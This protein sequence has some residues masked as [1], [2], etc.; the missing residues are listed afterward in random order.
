[1]GSQ[2]FQK[3]HFLLK[4]Q[5][6]WRFKF[7]LMSLGFINLSNDM[8]SLDYILGL[9]LLFSMKKNS[10]SHILFCQY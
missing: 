5:V 3:L 7:D 2:E 9:I 8:L 4:N 1:M 10:L 6:I